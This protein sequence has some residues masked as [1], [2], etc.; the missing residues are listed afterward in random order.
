MKAPHRV[1]R[2][3]RALSPGSLQGRLLL[4]S[5][6]AT[7]IA[8]GLVLVL[9]HQVLTRFVVGQIDQR[10]DNKIVA[11]ASQLRVAADGTLSLQGDADGPP[12]DKRHH[13][14]FW[15]VIAPHRTIAT[16]WLEPGDVVAPTR[17]D[18][19]E[20]M[21][22][23]APPGPGPGGLGDHPRTLDGAGLGGRLHQRIAK[24]VV[25]GVP[26]T[27]LVAAPDDAISGPVVEAMTTVGVGVVVLG[28]VLIALAYA[29]VRLGLRP[30][31]ALRRQVVEIGDGR[32]DRL[33]HRQPREIAPLV[34]E[35]NVLLEHNAA[36]L[37]RARRHVANLAHGL[38]T[39]LAT[40]SL[41]LDRVSDPD[42]TGLQGLVRDI[43]ARIGHHLG[44]ARGAALAGPS[45]ARTTLAEPLTD[46]LGV[47]GRIHEDRRLA[48]R[49]DC[50]A[51]AAVAC[52]RH[53]VE[54]MI[55]NLLDN[56]FRFARTRVECTAT[57]EGRDVV[58]AVVDDGPG[59]PTEK[60]AEAMEPGKR[61]DETQAGHGFGLSIAKEL[62]ELYG[63]SL[64]LSGESG[65]VA[66]LRLPSA[67]P[68][69][70]ARQTAA[71]NP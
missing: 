9:M 52:E 11:L 67:R 45:R 64:V 18:I 49:L 38:K 8:L 56:A 51:D 53:D 16:G 4:G 68:T 44:R 33:P 32:L 48:V 63:G 13:R 7:L 31:A 26:V 62:A 21:I 40:L 39:P 2:L 3:L 19:D 70:P 36:N 47:L 25:D 17:A 24:V 27:I 55:G 28:C 37:E 14:S 10:L 42:R 5:T 65:M 50:S 71:G 22:R 34:R 66:V 61:I 69:A 35:V 46:V 54:E 23:H 59:L 60:V 1:S 58:V 57:L 43:E 12:F 41:G 6:L 20:A 15:M 29:Q 30:L